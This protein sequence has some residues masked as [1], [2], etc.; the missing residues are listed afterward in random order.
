MKRRFVVVHA[1]ILKQYSLVAVKANGEIEIGKQLHL[2][3][4]E[5]GAAMPLSRAPVTKDIHRDAR[6]VLQTAQLRS[7]LDS[8]FKQP[9][10]VASYISGVDAIL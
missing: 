4:I 10:D 3:R 6:L 2:F 9:I 5:S 1:R 8:P 7:S